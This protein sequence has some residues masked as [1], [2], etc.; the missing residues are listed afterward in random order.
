MVAAT[1][2]GKVQFDY[3]ILKLQSTSL[4]SVQ[5]EEKLIHSAGQS[6]L[7]G[8]VIADT[9]QQ[10]VEAGGASSRICTAVASVQRWRIT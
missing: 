9:P 8:A 4:A 10:A 3:N 5:T 1:Q 2:I 7:Y 6:L